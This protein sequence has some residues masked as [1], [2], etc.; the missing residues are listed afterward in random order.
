MLAY[1]R[2]NLFLQSRYYD[3]GP[4]EDYEDSIRKTRM[5]HLPT[6]VNNWEQL[7]D[8]TPLS[9]FVGLFMPLSIDTN[10]VQLWPVLTVTAE[11]SGHYQSIMRLVF[12]ISRQ[13]TRIT[14]THYNGGYTIGVNNVSREIINIL[15]DVRPRRKWEQFVEGF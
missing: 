6:T 7:S 12:A 14:M 3:S 15:K 10:Y 11:F 4:I 2:L 8:C 13:F 5:S 1:G 9:N